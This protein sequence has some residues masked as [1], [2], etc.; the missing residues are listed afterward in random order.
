MT[1]VLINSGCEMANFT[2][3]QYGMASTKFRWNVSGS[4]MQAL[5]RVISIDSNGEEREFLN[6]Y[7]NDSNS[8]DQVFLKGYQ[9]PFDVNKINGSSR[10]D[11]LANNEIEK[12]RRVFLDY[13]T[14][15]TGYN[16]ESLNAE[17]S[18]YLINCGA[19][20]QSPIER[21]NKINNK[22][23][24]LYMDNGIDLYNEPLE[25]AVCAQHCNGGVKVDN[26]YMTTV[27]GLYA[28]GE[29]AG[30][31]GVTRQGGTALNSTQVGGIR[32]ARHISKKHDVKIDSD[33]GESE[34]IALTEKAKQFTVKQVHYFDFINKMSLYAGFNRDREKMLMLLDEVQGFLDNDVNEGLSISQYYYDHDM[35]ISAKA[36]L[37]AILQ[38]MKV[39]GSR[40]GAMYLENGKVISEKEGSRESMS[41][42]RDGKIIFEKVK[43][44]PTINSWFEDLLREQSDKN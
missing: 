32:V 8:L 35:M 4:Y 3:W 21:L 34:K 37:V 18:E 9:W 11:I 36:L 33:A 42:L 44:V 31:F 24:K 15:S 6:D 26:N 28:V 16:F 30:V 5:P 1:G 43:K 39:V 7:Y 27:E 17:T 20:L 12:G 25:I 22:A 2:E 41:I 23:I 14:N 19:N 10:V 38:T 29:V 40:G 13:R